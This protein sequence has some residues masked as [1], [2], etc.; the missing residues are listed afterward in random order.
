MATLFVDMPDQNIPQL[1]SAWRKDLVDLYQSGKEARLQNVMEGYSE[2][3]ELTDDYLLLQ[4]SERST[5]EMKLF[6]LV[7]NTSIIC[8][9]TTVFGPAPDSRVQFY[10]TD[11]ELLNS[12]D[13]I[14]PESIS[15]FFKEDVNRSDDTYL[16]AM[17]RL[18]MQM[19]HYSL[20]PDSLTLS[21]TFSTP[22]YLS[23]E[24]RKAV[25]PFL[26]QEPRVYIWER[27]HF[28]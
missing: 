7:N 14:T 21:A 19:F 15:W 25:T 20:S 22:L 16:D 24:E 23:E 13:L 10:S 8:V 27:Y 18:D 2:L 28:N 3:K 17:A 9:V 4:A 11:W 1:E 12:G 6:P 26:K 5:V